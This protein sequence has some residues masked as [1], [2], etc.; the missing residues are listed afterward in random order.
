ML[1]LAV[2][3]SLVESGWLAEA[4]FGVAQ[5]CALVAVAHAARH[6]DALDP[7]PWSLLAAGLGLLSAAELYWSWLQLTDPNA[8]PSP[9]DA[10]SA[11]GLLVV[12]VALWRCATRVSPV[13]DRTGFV[14][15]AAVALPA[16]TLAWVLI[17]EPAG[18][19]LG[20]SADEQTWIAIG[21]ALDVALLAMGARLAFAL[22]ARPPAYVF[23]YLAIGGSM[24]VDVLDSVLEVG[25]G[26]AVG[27]TEDVVF[28]ACAG[29]WVA[30]AMSRGPVTAAPASGLQHLGARRQVLLITC[31]SVPL[32]ALTVLSLRGAPL[33]STT[34]LVAGVA[35]A[36]LSGLVMVRIFSLVGVTRRL[37]DEQGRERFAA[38]VE[39]ASDVILT[40][41]SAHRITYASPSA[42][43]AWG[44]DP[45]S[46]V[47]RPVTDLVAADDGPTLLSHLVRASALP[48]RSK[49][50]L[51]VRVE[52]FGGGHRICN[53]VAANLADHPGVRGISMTCGDVTEQRSL[54]A[55]LSKRA[56]NDELTGLA[57]RALFTDRIGQSLRRRSSDRSTTA[58]LFLDLDDFKQIN[59]GLGHGA[60]D[61]LLIAVARRLAECVRPGD[62]VARLGGDEFGILLEHPCDATEAVRVAARLVEI[63]ALPLEVGDLRLSARASIGIALSHDGAEAHSLLRDADIA[64]YEAKGSSRGAWVVFD[65][66]M[67]TAAAGRIS[68]RS[69]L[70]SALIAHELHLAYQPIY[71][72]RTRRM[73]SVESLLR[74]TH[75]TRGVVSPADFIPLA[76]RTGQIL[77]IGTWVLQQAC[78]AASRW[79]DSGHPVGVAVNVSAI[80]FQ[81]AGFVDRVGDVLRTTGLDPHRL[82]IEMTETA[83]MRD[84]EATAALLREI[85]ASGVKIAIDDFGT[86]YCSL[87]YLKRFAVDFLKIDRSFVCEVTA[88][89]TNLLVHNIIG[90]ADSLGIPTVAEGIELA[91]QLE[92]LTQHQCRFG[93][94]FHL[95]RPM[96]A[97]DLTELLARTGGRLRPEPASAAGRT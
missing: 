61:Q 84:P 90:L 28:I 22:K 48:P 89:S 16:A 58:L 6:R 43:T 53:A 1:C 85:R 27:R 4:M 7:T 41:D 35:G 10:L 59:D 77:T 44:Y 86:G 31:A 46:L 74:W 92:N 24:L 50:T 33:S 3:R 78:Q 75:P 76:E 9:A 42:Q 82:T 79:N 62:T 51:E 96:P 97:A 37:A 52:R 55:Q 34:V 95:A 26:S 13:G 87:A 25:F 20:L 72:L 49:L 36:V 14:D 11:T 57:N 19:T 32:A 18:R 2:A 30:A 64:M 94:G 83:I 68:L 15:A 56:F 91:E 45:R 23:I 70:E 71:D 65:P 40:V 60:G 88:D 12:V 54:E 29:F 81:D 47:G 5:G 66:D 73:S 80:Q 63:L 93:Q 67:R 39:N 8:F 17:I 69:D 38:M 21:L